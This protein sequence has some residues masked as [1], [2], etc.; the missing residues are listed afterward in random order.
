MICPNCK[1]RVDPATGNAW[2][3]VLEATASAGT[4]DAQAVLFAVYLWDQSAMHVGGQ[5][6]L[7]TELRDAVR[8]KLSALAT[9][10]V[11]DRLD[12]VLGGTS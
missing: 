10:E 4:Q 5:S 2:L 11:V 1:T 9:P 12:E 8:V 6:V 3:G 7:P